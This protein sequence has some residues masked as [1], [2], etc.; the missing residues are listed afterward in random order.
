M[1]V[2]NRERLAQLDVLR[3]VAILLVLGTHLVPPSPQ[4]VG[5]VIASV[6]GRLGGGWIGVDLFFVLSGFLVSGLLFREY[7]A[8]GTVRPG[9]FL[10]RRA[11]KIYPP[12]YVLTFVALAVVGAPNTRDVIGELFFL[13]NYVG[14][15]WGITWSL[16]VEEHFYLLLAGYAWCLVM[17]R[18]DRPF[19]TLP[20]VFVAVATVCLLLRV[21]NADEPYTHFTHLFPTHLR[22]DSLMFGVLLAYGWHFGQLQS[23]A[24]PWRAS[25]CVGGMLMLS[26]AFLF[27]LGTT[28]WLHVYGLT[29]GYLGSGALLVGLLSYELPRTRPVRVL[30]HIGVFRIPSIC[31]TGRSED[32]RGMR[33]WMSGGQC[34][35][36][37]I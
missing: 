2:L 3:G 29:L 13:Q 5:W 11:F 26:P 9:R 14:S 17:L 30:S 25:L 35:R 37:P 16:A 4:E 27:P 15:L 23:Y 22:I 7:Q 28:P 8:T 36:A 6:A 31:I 24:R 21:A 32:S 20:V 12:F 33:C 18:Q 34:L 19:A 10:I 1:P